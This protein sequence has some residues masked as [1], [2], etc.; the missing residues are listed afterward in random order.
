MLRQQRDPHYV[1]DGFDEVYIPQLP[2]EPRKV[3][4]FEVSP[5][6]P[7]KSAPESAISES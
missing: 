7:D 4:G 5:R 1:Y 2:K 6:V 3:D